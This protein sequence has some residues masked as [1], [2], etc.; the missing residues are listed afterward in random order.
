MG[1]F[2]K[3]DFKKKKSDY[4]K[5][6]EIPV[7][8]FYYHNKK[9]LKISTGVK[10][11]IRNWNYDYKSTR[12]QNPI[13]KSD[14]ESKT[15]NLELVS[16]LVE[17]NDIIHRINVS[18]EDEP[19]TDLI[20]SLL[21][22][23]EYKRV[24]STL[25]K[26]H[27]TTLFNEYT[28]W[29]FSDE[30]LVI[31]QNRNSY[32]SALK[33]SFDD[34]IDFSNEY[35]RKEKIKL[36]LENITLEWISEFLSELE[37]NK[38]YLPSTINKRIKVLR[39][40]KTWLRD[41][42]NI[43]F[44]LVIPKK[45]FKEPP[46][47]VICLNHKQILELHNFKEFDASNEKHSK[48]LVKE[49]TGVL[50]IEDVL[51]KSKRKSMYT[52]YEVY[53]DMLVWMCITGMRFSDTVN[54]TVLSKDF[55]SGGDRKLGE[56]KYTSIKTNTLIY[57]P[58]VNITE[59]LFE[60]YS[61]GK[62]ADQYLFPLTE[63]GNKISNQKMNKH[64]K[65]ICRIIGF[66]TMVK[67]PDFG[68]DGLPIEGTDKPKPLWEWVGTHIGRRS[69]IRYHI[70]KGTPVHTIKSMTGHTSTRVFEKYFS[71]IKSDRMKSMDYG[72][73]LD[74]GFSTI[75]KDV[76]QPKIKGGLTPRK[77]ELLLELKSS[78]D[79]GI[80]HEEQWKKSV[81]EVMNS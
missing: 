41:T 1:L 73:T 79:M 72:Y 50:Y 76:K 3:L 80:I 70:E 23:N 67:N 64:I 59:N 2:F 18:G 51:N 22:K 21:L 39:L 46:R 47:E 28:N 63:N 71:I 19:S 31:T 10:S 7:V 12:S 55:I 81:E 69:F 20:K 24:K 35:Q 48:Y 66:N 38:G 6:E 4:K 34:I 25:T 60:K 74:E 16:K 61:S 62:S 8:L 30:Y 11:S 58:I 9:K 49:G 17:V 27:F 65:E 54:L 57:V 37:K 44:N 5:S 33:T 77:K 29:F 26:V 78:L 15:K 53:K 40:F 45:R 36:L 13:K 32:R 75:K 52:N 68:S 56:I 14:K 43:S 42:K